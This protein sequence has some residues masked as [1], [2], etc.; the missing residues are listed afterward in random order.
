MTNLLLFL[1]YVAGVVALVLYGA[2]RLDRYEDQ[3]ERPFDW[4]RDA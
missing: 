3:L 2:W 4:E 1:F